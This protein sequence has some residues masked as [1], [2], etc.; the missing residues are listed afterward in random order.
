MLAWKSLC[1]SAGR[2]AVVV[3][4]LGADK[5]VEPLGKPRVAPERANLFVLYRSLPIAEATQGTVLD[6]CDFRALDEAARR[7]DFS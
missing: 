1:E 3:V 5:V 2:V 6:L 4:D 7:H